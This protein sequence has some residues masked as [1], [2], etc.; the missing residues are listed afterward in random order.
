MCVDVQGSKGGFENTVFELQE[1]SPGIERFPG[2]LWI[3]LE[4]CGEEIVLSLLRLEDLNPS[5]WRMIQSR[6]RH[7]KDHNDPK[8][9]S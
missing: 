5:I 4:T 6:N 8:R 9:S 3:N 7:K 1:G 2:F